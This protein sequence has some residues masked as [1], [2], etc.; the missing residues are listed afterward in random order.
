VTWGKVDPDQLSDTVVCYTDATIALPVMA[1][2]ALT[3]RTPRTLR[4]LYDRRGEMLAR[5]AS[6]F[7]KKQKG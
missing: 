4:R 6:D 3:K 7:L 1:A 5:L 2:Y